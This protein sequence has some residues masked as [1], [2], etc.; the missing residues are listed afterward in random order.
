VFVTYA[1]KN[2]ELIAEL[3]KY[4]FVNRGGKE[5]IETITIQSVPG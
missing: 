2:K 3:E 5:A 4:G 1:A